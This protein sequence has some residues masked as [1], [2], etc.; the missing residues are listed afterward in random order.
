MRSKTVAKSYSNSF[1]KY[2][3]HPLNLVDE[4]NFKLMI[5]IISILNGNGYISYIFEQGEMYTYISV[6]DIE[7]LNIL[8]K[9]Q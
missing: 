9:Y 7:K 8:T 5:F 1:I 6:L 2:H 4:L 3:H